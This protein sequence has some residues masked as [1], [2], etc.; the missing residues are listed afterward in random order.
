MP[1]REKGPSPTLLLLHMHVGLLLLMVP[2]WQTGVLS[3]QPNG[4]PR[5]YVAPG[6]KAVRDITRTGG[7]RGQNCTTTLP[8]RQMYADLRALPVDSQRVAG[9]AMCPWFWGMY[10]ADEISGRR[11][12]GVCGRPLSSVNKT[13]RGSWRGQTW[14]HPSR[15]WGAELDHIDGD[16]SNGH[17]S[18]FEWLCINCHQA[19]TRCQ[20]K[21]GTSVA[22]RPLVAFNPECGVCEPLYDV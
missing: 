8:T 18:N 2:L 3:R 6:M 10:L 22:W 12:Q 1:V 20:R 16:R 15:P 17:I 4:R 21:F 13:F 9:R 14:Q 11:C 5:E 19:K 7:R